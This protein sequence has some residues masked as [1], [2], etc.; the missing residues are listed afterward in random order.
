M[1]YFNGGK[2]VEMDMLAKL[3]LGKSPVGQ[4]ME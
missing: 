2:G 3:D 4:Q 1:E